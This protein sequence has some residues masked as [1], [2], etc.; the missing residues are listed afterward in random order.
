MPPKAVIARLSK[1]DH[2]PHLFTIRPFPTPVSHK[3]FLRINLNRGSLNNLDIKS[4]DLCHITTAEISE[5]AKTPIIP[6]IA[7][8]ASDAHLQK[9]IALISDNVRTALSVGF[10]D[11][12]LI[13]KY[14]EKV[15]DAVSVFVK[16]IEYEEPLPTAARP[17]TTVPKKS[18]VGI[19]KNQI[20]GWRWFL[21]HVL[22]ET[23]YISEGL[24]LNAIEYKGVKRAFRIEKIVAKNLPRE[25]NDEHSVPAYKMTESTIIELTTDSADPCSS[26]PSPAR[27]KLTRAP[28][29]SVVEENP[30][31]TIALPS[32]T[33]F[34]SIGGLSK[35]I[36]ALK[37]LLLSTLYQSHHFT[38]FN[39]TPP[40]GILLYGPPGTGKTL[41]LKAIASELSANCFVLNGSI[42]GKYMGESEAAVRRVFAEARAHQ[43]AIVFV[44]EVDSLA[45]KRTAG[46]S[47]EGRVV[48]TLLTEMDGLDYSGGGEV[49]KVVVVAATNRPNAVDGALRRPGRFDREI[50]VGI[51]DVDS[52]REI[53]E[54]LM[55]E[56][57]FEGREGKGK[58][59]FV[60]ELAARTHGFVGADLESLVRTGFTVGL[61]RL[62]L[63]EGQKEEKMEEEVVIRENDIEAALK[64]VRPTAMREIFLEPP[65][66]RW[67]DI[68][69][70]EE[71]KQRLREAVEW[72]LTHPEVFSR[73]GGTPR[74]GLLLYG[75]PGCS[76]TLT[77]KALATEAGLN[78]MAVKG[79]ELFSMYVGESERAVREIFRKARAAS[80][81]II[82]FDEIDALSASREGR[83][84]KS[85]GGG[86]GAS[87]L[88]ALLNEMDGIESLKNVTIL[89]ATNRPEI[90]D[91][92]L[93]RP[94]R[95][96]TILYVGP[97]DLDARK[98]I[99]QIKTKKM[100][101]SPDV[102]LDILA[103]KMDGYSG[104]EI[105]NIC[106]EA[107]HYAMRESFDIDAV[108]KTHFD[109]AMEKAVPQITRDMRMRY[110][111]W[112]V[113][114]VKKI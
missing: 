98:Q 43:P 24:I 12:V 51:P 87:V 63:V 16:E 53:L 70:Q 68:G 113:G 93:L 57:P 54:V 96:D 33:T 99:L 67:S 32:R 30:P 72:P 107:I 13:G 79:P 109:Q 95:L 46:D 26:R 114:G 42:V 36:D 65:K 27:S 18:R 8:L 25:I 88:T 10:E 77:A 105:V 102:D 19:E 23:K 7:W 66:V 41:L 5:T 28:R 80:P 61:K 3:T 76:K 101:I 64:D 55:K 15:E 58:E 1:G 34:A 104:A 82:F 86:V 60:K 40:R 59:E 21:E 37:T 62:E 78:F 75:P 20:E 48:T 94:G 22:V 29:A 17:G 47:G 49:V 44:D 73:L 83:Q 112:S 111:R 110:E 71:V 74:K 45:P 100:S 11:K 56:L 69:G 89:A 92:A 14:T 52:R 39:L 84:G 106:D 35:Q 2:N 38:R 4:G 85:G 81:S 31:V 91:P 6:A 50:E 90:I 97:P 9:G 103:K 108:G